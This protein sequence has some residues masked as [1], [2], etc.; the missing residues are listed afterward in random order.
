[1]PRVQARYLGDPTQPSSEFLQDGLYG[2][3][4]VGATVTPDIF[5]NI[6]TRPEPGYYWPA[7]RCGSGQPTGVKAE[8]F[9]DSRYKN[10]SFATVF[11]E[12]VRRLYKELLTGRPGGIGARCHG[13]GRSQ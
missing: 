13:A 1:M 5:S 11:P 3:D 10:V 4:T 8:D 6:L 9:V 7:D 12:Q 2:P